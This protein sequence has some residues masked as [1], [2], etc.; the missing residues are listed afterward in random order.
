M[1]NGITKRFNRTL[2]SMIGTLENEKKRDWKTHLP[3]LVHA[4]NATR[5]ETTGFSP[6]ELLFGRTPKLPVDLLFGTN[7]TDHENSNSADYIT[8]LRNKL[9]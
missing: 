6:F 9:Q 2:I 7:S 5:H 4:Y 8:E 3:S 1:S